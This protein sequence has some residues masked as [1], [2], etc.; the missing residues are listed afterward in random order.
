ML[1]SLSL[2]WLDGVVGGQEAGTTNRDSW[3]FEVK[4]MRVPGL[5][6]IPAPSYQSKTERTEVGRC[7][8]ES[9]S[10]CETKGGGSSTV[11]QCQLD[12][13]AA[14]WDNRKR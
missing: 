6:Y 14:C 2:N 4:P 11:G 9:M 1:E 7:I 8:D 12:G 13:I 5:G 10:R 3:S